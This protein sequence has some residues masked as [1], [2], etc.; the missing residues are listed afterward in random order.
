[1]WFTWALSLH[2][3][4]EPGKLAAIEE[5]P[6]RAFGLAVTELISGQ[7]VC[8]QQ[9][10]H[11]ILVYSKVCLCCGN[12]TWL[13]GLKRQCKDNGKTELEGEH[14]QII[15]QTEVVTYKAGISPHAFAINSDHSQN[16]LHSLLSRYSS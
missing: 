12:Q 4:A 5:E 10:E 7:W 9:L 1:M 8:E 16:L 3:K 14:E 2:S 13:D 11:G 15:R 6:S